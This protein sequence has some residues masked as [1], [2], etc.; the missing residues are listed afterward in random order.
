M[1][2]TVFRYLAKISYSVYMVHVIISIFFAVF[3]EQF[4]PSLIGENWNETG[5]G[6]DIYIL[7]Y[8]S[9]V[10]VCAH[11]TYHFIE[12]PGRKLINRID[13]GRLTRQSKTSALS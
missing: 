6:G 4:L 11:I 3:A 7:I 1:S 8:L 10:I 5:L 2:H 9:V 13:I 12:V